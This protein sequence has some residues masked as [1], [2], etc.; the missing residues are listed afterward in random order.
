MAAVVVLVLAAVGAGA[1]GVW[2]NQQVLAKEPLALEESWSKLD[3]ASCIAKLAPVGVATKAGI[4]SEQTVSLREKELNYLVQG[5]ALADQPDLKV[6]IEY[7]DSALVIHFSKRV[8]FNRYVNG[9]LATQLSGENGLF[10]V[11][12]TKLAT[13]N[14]TWPAA[15]HPV[16]A[17]AIKSTLDNQ[18]ALKDQGLMITGLE[19]TGKALKLTIKTLKK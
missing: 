1:G 5:M 4:E 15:F 3:E 7:G 9:E 17:G 10:N 19:F 16:V 14:L 6:K 12:V 8:K 13:G 2:L 11:K 18:T